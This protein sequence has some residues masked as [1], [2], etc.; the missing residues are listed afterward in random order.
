MKSLL[1]TILPIIPAF[2]IYAYLCSELNFTQDDSYISYRYVANYL[3]GDG[4]VYNVGERVE[5]FTNF[6]WV[7][8]LI[9]WGALGIGYI[10]VSKLT[11]FIFGAGVIYITYLI[12]QHVFGQRDRWFSLLPVYLL[13]VNQSLAYWSPAGLETAAFAFFAVVSVYLYLR[14]SWFLIA[15]L[16]LAVWLRPE[17]AVLT[18]I[19]IVVEAIETRKVPAFTLKC[20]VAA[21]VFS[22]PY[23]VFKHAYYGSILPNPFYAKTGPDLSQLLNG[24]EYAGRFFSHYGFYGAGVLIPLWFYRKLPEHARSLWLT[25]VLFTLY[26]LVVGGDV[27]KVHRFFLPVLGLSAVL[28]TLSL[29]LVVKKLT[30]K[31]R[32]MILLLAAVPLMLLTYYLPDRFVRDYNGREKRFTT[33]MGF[34]AAELA[35]A[36]STNFSVALSTIGIFGYELVGHEIID[37]LGL[38]DS[39][40]ARYSEEPIEGMKTTWKEQKHNSR[41]LLQKGPDYIAFSTGVKPSA[42]AERALLLF[43][44]FLDCY[45]TI[46]WFYQA[47]RH[48]PRGTVQ[49]VFKKIGEIEGE[50]VP[51]YPVE[52]V[53]NYKIAL[54]HYGGGDQRKAVEYYDRAIR[55]SPEPVY[56][57]LLY[58]KAFSH[59]LLREHETAQ[60]LLNAVVERDSL[61]FMAHKDLY[62]YAMAMGDSA[63]AEAHERWLK[64]T[65]PWYW[66]RVQALGSLA[67][68]SAAGQRR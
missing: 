11:G 41:Y 44:Q 49:S 13:A 14:R 62:M 29:W 43:P 6:G 51:S 25:F 3:N 52:W 45:R 58:Q 54:D 59:F 64:K 32:N 46:G 12:A 26:I 66:P 30:R 2:L 21:F 56:I 16:S 28:L 24:L 7:I 60:R 9:L 36:D 33:R 1:K 35:E 39:T 34:L 67:A 53:E 4:L 68:K 57:Y 61:I 63:K 42:P 10:A 48:D 37:M 15:A 5:G 17:G 40:I 38:T 47:R 18:A 50:L 22:V 65:V 20:G 8:Y 55:A 31:T 19:L 27:L 23:V